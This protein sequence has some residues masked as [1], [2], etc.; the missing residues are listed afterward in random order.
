M[1]ELP[2]Q[3]TRLDELI[4]DWGRL[5]IVRRDAAIKLTPK[6]AAVLCCL[7]RQPDVTLTRKALLDEVWPGTFSSDEVLTQVVAEL[8]RALEDPAKD[9]R[10]IAT[11]PKLGYR[12]IGPAPRAAEHE[13]HLANTSNGSV[14]LSNETTTRDGAHPPSRGTATSDARRPLLPL[15]AMTAIAALV[16]ASMY[17]RDGPPRESAATNVAAAPGPVS[18]PRPIATEPGHD[19]D[20]AISAD[21]RRVAY[22][23]SS[24]DRARLRV[25]VLDALGYT[26]LEL[27][28]AGQPSSPAWSPDGRQLAYLWIAGDTCELRRVEI[29][30]RAVHAITDGCT[31]TPPG[32][33]DWSPDGAFLVYSHADLQGQALGGRSISIYRIAPDG[34]AIAR[35]SNSHRWLTVDAHPRVSSDSRD[36]AFVRDSEGRHRVMVVG[37]D[38][39]GSEREVPFSRWPYRVAWRGRSGKLA[40][41]AHG[42]T[43]TEIWNIDRDGS[44][45]TLV[46]APGAGPGLSVSRDGAFA[47]FE[48]RVI[49]DNIWSLVMDGPDVAPAQV[50]RGTRSELAPRLSPDGATLAYLADDGGAFEVTLTNL[51]TG[52]RRRLSHFAPRAPVDL[53]WSPSGK[54]LAV[55]LGTESGKHVAVLGRDGNLIALPASI[56][57]WLVSQV[58]WTHDESHLLVAIESGGRRELHRLGFPAFDGDEIMTD[59]SIGAFSS[60]FDAPLIYISDARE[61]T[62]ER[63]DSSFEPAVVEGVKLQAAPSDQWLVR[64][65]VLAQMTQVERGADAVLRYAALKPG[66]ETIE[67]RITA[68]EPPLGRNFDLGGGKLWYTSRDMDNVDLVMLPLPGR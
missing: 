68:P 21:G 41:A 10:W 45:P 17:L 55:I 20:P 66:G 5:A 25:R 13:S 24:N 37:N 64:D 50:T 32:T 15:V 6:A 43:P 61:C 48:Q 14:E 56:S 67:R 39:S 23:H 52:E 38:G 65:G 59:N 60:A 34:T 58:E 62:L 49:D 44:N 36:V 18:V 8:R 40:V 54:Y 47:V 4:I 30:T 63:L 31:V 3:S 51:S 27:E 46:A 19:L 33:I 11:V 12:W 57:A 28:G 1:I 7:L 2:T 35:L 29:D 53:R 42:T 22:I 16:V 26:D 9:G